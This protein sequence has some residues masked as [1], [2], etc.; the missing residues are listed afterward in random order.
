[1]ADFIAAIGL[2][3]VIH[4][5]QDVILQIG[6]TESLHLNWHGLPDY[7]DRAAAVFKTPKPGISSL[8][9]P[10]GERLISEMQ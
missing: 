5:M 8:E 1:M 7:L 9:R 4:T 2:V 3:L 6:I 10:T